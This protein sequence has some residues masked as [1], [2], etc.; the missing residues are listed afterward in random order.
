MTCPSLTEMGRGQQG[1]HHPE[2]SSFRR[3]SKEVRPVFR[4]RGQP[5][6]VEKNPA[7]PDRV[8]SI[9]RGE[10]SLGFKLGKNM[11]VQRVPNPSFI[12]HP[13]SWRRR[14]G[15]KSPMLLPLRPRLNPSAEDVHFLFGQ[16]FAA[17]VGWHPVLLA[18]LGDSPPHFAFVQ[19]SWNHREI[20]PEIPH[21]SF[22]GVESEIGFLFIRPVTNQAFLGKD[23]PHIPQ[24][25]NGL[26]NSL[27]GREG[28]DQ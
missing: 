9:L 10:F 13:G 27:K 14:K 23:G 12:L 1:I 2:S 18:G 3:L 7:E 26:I 25:I 20:T 8:G 21:D 17:V 16:G 15:R 19:I 22:V 5:G 4:S 6:Q 11:D 24:E 28:D